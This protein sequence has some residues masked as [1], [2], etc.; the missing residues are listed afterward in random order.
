MEKI[1]L[2]RRINWYASAPFIKWMGPYESQLEAWEAIR[3]LDG[4]P[5]DEGRV[6]CTFDTYNS[7]TKFTKDV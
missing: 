3:G 6:W 5:V 2:K 7:D 1:D 4:L